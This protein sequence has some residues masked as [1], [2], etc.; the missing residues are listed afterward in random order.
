MMFRGLYNFNLLGDD[1]LLT[2]GTYL[3]IKGLKGRGVQDL[4][5]SLQVVLSLR[6]SFERCWR[7]T[8]FLNQ[9][10]SI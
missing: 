4:Q 6:W 10:Q 1:E 8:V 2:K 5:D 9:F 3:H 7:L